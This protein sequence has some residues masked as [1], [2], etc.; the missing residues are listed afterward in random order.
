METVTKEDLDKLAERITAAIMQKT[1]K[2]EPKEKYLTLEQ[3]AK[4]IGDKK[5]RLG[6]KVRN[7]EISY[8]KDGR[9]IKFCIADL[10]AH[11]MARRIPSNAEIAS[12]AS[13]RR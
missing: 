1:V 3:A 9:L 10:D 7:G 12:L 2:P 5:S 11:M 13:V 8:I 4:Y 6:E